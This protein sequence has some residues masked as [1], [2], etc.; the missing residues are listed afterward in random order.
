MSST[1]DHVP[2]YKL[3][4]ARAFPSGFE[5]SDVLFEEMNKI[6]IFHE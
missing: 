5:V 2:N 3:S 1:V 4:E 6:K